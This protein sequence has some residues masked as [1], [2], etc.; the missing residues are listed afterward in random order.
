MPY[1]LQKHHR[2]SI[3]LKGYDY[4]QAGAYFVTFCAWQHECLFG[5]IVDGE[6]HLNDYGR[7]VEEEWLRTAEV[8]PNVDLDAFVIMP[9]HIHGIIVICIDPVGASRRLAP[10]NT[11]TRLVAGSLGAII[12]QIKSVT[13]KRINVL[14]SMP[15]QAVWQRNYYERIIRSEAALDNIRQYI[16]TVARLPAC[17]WA[18][19]FCMQ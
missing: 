2:R 18:S 4:T 1:D 3:R 5:E 7:V 15:G 13:T 10:T 8:R 14:R 9:N 11:P 6:M 16:E 19:P 12:G 17:S